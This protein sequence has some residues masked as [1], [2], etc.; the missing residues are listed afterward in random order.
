[1]WSS[2]QEISKVLV[3]SDQPEVSIASVK[4]WLV[5]EI[6]YWVLFQT[7]APPGSVMFTSIAYRFA[8]RQVTARV[9]ESLTQVVL[10]DLGVVIVVAGF[11]LSTI[12][13]IVSLD[14]W[15]R[16]SLAKTI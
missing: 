1:M 10:S 13:V 8:S 15:P 3:P 11:V 9:I 16:V 12:N 4:D 14:I 6:S 5:P 2:P 7:E